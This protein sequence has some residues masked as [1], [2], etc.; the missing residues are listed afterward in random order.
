MVARFKKLKKRK[1]VFQTIFL[2]ALF[3]VLIIGTIAYLVVSNLNI[4]H[5]RA[6]LITQIEEIQ[7]EIDNLE[8]K[9]QEL[10]IGINKTER[11]DYQREKLYEQGY[12][13]KGEHQVIVLPPE[14]NKELS[15][16]EQKGL[17]QRF[18]DKLGF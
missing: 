17:W 16:E 12:V 13:E 14:K 1:E 18:L 15:K 2:S 11:E 5:K 8:Q 6:E 10:E 3:A 7:K 4:K 9:N